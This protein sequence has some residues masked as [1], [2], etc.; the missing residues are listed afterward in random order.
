VRTENLYKALIQ[1]DHRRR[2]HRLKIC[3][4]SSM[5]CDLPISNNRLQRQQ[6]Q[7]QSLCRNG[8]NNNIQIRS[9]N[10][11]FSPDIIQ[12]FSL[13]GGTGVIINSLHSDIGLPYWV[14]FSA[15]NFMLRASLLPIVIYGARTAA[16]YA[17]VAPEVQFIVASSDH[18]GIF[19][20][21]WR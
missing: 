17:K 7:Q 3:P 9:M 14:T 13:W 11:W 5:R 21:T 4:L 1:D 20:H 12:D 18:N 8:M 6:Q 2:P 15:M 10:S 19:D 16:R